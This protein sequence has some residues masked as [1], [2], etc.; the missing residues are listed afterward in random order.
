MIYTSLL[1][2]GD[3]ADTHGRLVAYRVLAVGREYTDRPDLWSGLSNAGPQPGDLLKISIG[4]LPEAFVTTVQGATAASRF[5]L[6]SAFIKEYKDLSE[7]QR[8][9]AF[10]SLL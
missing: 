7:D 9:A 4:D 6:H 1:A 8:E 5:A 3:S 2:S 10:E